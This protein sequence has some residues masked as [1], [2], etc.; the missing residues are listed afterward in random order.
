[1]GPFEDRWTRQ[2]GARKHSFVEVPLE[3]GPAGHLLVRVGL[4]HRAGLVFL[5]DSGA[6]GSVIAR[7]ALWAEARERLTMDESEPVH[8][9]GGSFAEATMLPVE[10]LTLGSWERGRVE[11]TVL[12][13]AHLKTG[14]GTGIDGILGLDVLGQHEL[15]LDLRHN[16]LILSWEDGPEGPLGLPVEKFAS[17]SYRKS[18]DGL[19]VLEVTL[20]DTVEMP[21]ILDLG[22]A[23][24][25]INGVAAR[26][27]RAPQNRLP[28]ADKDTMALGADNRG[29]AA[30]LQDIDRIQVGGVDLAPASVYVSDLPVFEKLGYAEQP[31]ML[32]GL[33]VLR[34]RVIGF[35]F[36]R[37][38][39]YLC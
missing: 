20:N 36:E 37:C 2:V 11:L 8:A 23:T 32:L 17:H 29:V 19:I 39:V 4:D 24:S 25:L 31:I 9:A 14:L 16:R 22:A 30:A 28:Q 35:N 5:V 27:L 12:D 33:D 26:L 38:L 10:R 1:V 21:S 7:S 3:P 18:D 6:S 34:G 15:W 13:L